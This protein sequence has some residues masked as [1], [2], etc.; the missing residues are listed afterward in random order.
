[1]STVQ[2]DLVVNG[3]C[4]IIKIIITVLISHAWL[5]KNCVTAYHIFL[6][7]YIYIHVRKKYFPWKNYFINIIT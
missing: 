4:E 6:V 2:K 1:M 3:I 5:L 7:Y